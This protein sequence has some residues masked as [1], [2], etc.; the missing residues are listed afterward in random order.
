LDFHE[1]LLNFSTGL[2]IKVNSK[3]IAIVVCK[4]NLILFNK[5]LESLKF[6]ILFKLIYLI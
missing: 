4:I 6:I 5:L 1:I 2:L 3:N